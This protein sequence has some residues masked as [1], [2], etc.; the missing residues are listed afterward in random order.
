MC[1]CLIVHFQFK[2]RLKLWYRRNRLNWP[3]PFWIFQI[4]PPFLIRTWAQMGFKN[5]LHHQVA[6]WEAMIDLIFYLNASNWQLSWGGHINK[7]SRF[8]TGLYYKG[9][10]KGCPKMPKLA[11]NQSAICDWRGKTNMQKHLPPPGKAW[12]FFWWS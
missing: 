11:H 10:V 6:Q 8:I 7:G 5:L 9:I 2:R 3:S 1:P 12:N 4:F